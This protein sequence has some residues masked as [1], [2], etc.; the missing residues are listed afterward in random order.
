MDFSSKLLK[1]AVDEKKD[2]SDQ[3]PKWEKEGYCSQEFVRKLCKKS[4]KGAFLSS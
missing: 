4:C 1:N 2:S 3:C